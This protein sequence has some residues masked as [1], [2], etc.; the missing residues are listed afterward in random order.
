MNLKK[1]LRSAA[2]VAMLFSA[3][4][5]NAAIYQFNLTGDYTANWQLDSTVVPEDFLDKGF[6]MVTAEGEFPGAVSELAWVTFYNARYKGGL[7]IYD[8]IGNK[9]LLVT[10]G[11]QLYT[12]SESAPTFRLGTFGMTEA[13]NSGNFTLM[14]TDLSA[15]P[16]PVPEPATG[17]MLLGGLG[18]MYAFRKRRHGNTAPQ[19]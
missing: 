3:G 1:S 9:L 5:A 15:G 16:S 8:Y 17:A 18:L 11:P 19:P 2:L 7:E 14:V 6:F 12:G 13:R 4:V 10:D